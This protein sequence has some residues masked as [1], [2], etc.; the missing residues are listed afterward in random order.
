MIFRRQIRDCDH[1][2]VFESTELL[3][4]DLHRQGCTPPSTCVDFTCRYCYCEHRSTDLKMQ[5]E[6]KG[7]EYSL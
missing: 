4:V 6:S 2:T 3:D 5:L 7:V 1:L